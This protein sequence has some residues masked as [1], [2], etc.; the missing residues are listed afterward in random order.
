MNKIAFLT[1]TNFEGYWDG[2]MPNMRTEICWQVALGSYHINIWNYNKVKGYDHVFVIVPKGEVYLNL[3]GCKLKDGKNPISLLLSENF[4]EVLKNNNKN[5][6]FIQE[7][8]S[9]IQFNDYEIFDQI[10]YYNNMM[11]FD[12][13]FVHNEYDKLY[14]EGMYPNKRV[15]VISSLMYIHMVKD[16]I[17][18]PENK[19]IIGGNW[20]NFYRGFQSYSLADEIKDHEKWV[21]TSHAMREYEDQ[22]PDLHH[23]PRVMWLEWMKIL[24][25]FKCGIHLMNIRAAGTYFLNCGYYGIVAIGNKLVDTARL[26]YPDWCVDV[27]DIKS[28]REKMIKLNY[29][30]NDE[31]WLLNEANKAKENYNKYFSIDIWKEKMNNIIN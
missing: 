12:I 30:I 27:Y 11:N 24:S 28:A 16:F 17:W 15:E 5:V 20:S 10:N 8:G 25:T 7:G 6:Y 3:T 26:I 2:N 29:Y 19:I 22:V 31:K 18:K 21:M 14:F 1:E 4:V 23:L 13:L 9:D